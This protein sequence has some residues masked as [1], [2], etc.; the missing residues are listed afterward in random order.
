MTDLW[1]LATPYSAFPYGINEA[2]KTAALLSANLLLRGENVYSPIV[3]SHFICSVS[4]IDA[5]D[6]DFWMRADQPFMERCTGLIVGMLPTWS[7]S[8]GVAMEVEYFKREK[9]PVRYFD[10][11][12]D[13]FVGVV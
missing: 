11:E 8:K 5:Y 7:K 12:H 6:H 1:Y 9:K 2:A 4:G 3:H 13:C 10:P